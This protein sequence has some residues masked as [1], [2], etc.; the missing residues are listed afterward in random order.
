MKLWAALCLIYNGIF[1]STAHALCE[2]NAHVE[3]RWVLDSSID[4]KQFVCGYNPNFTEADYT[5]H[6]GNLN[7]E[8]SKGC[9][10][11]EADHTMNAVTQR[12][13]YQW[14]PTHCVLPKWDAISFCS[15]LGNRT[16]MIIGDSTMHQSSTTLMAMISQNNAKCAHQI[17]YGQSH[18]LIYGHPTNFKMVHQVEKF[19]RLHNH[20]PDIV[21]LTVGAHLG[22]MGDL[23]TIW[24]TPEGLIN[25]INFLRSNPWGQHHN[26]SFVWKTQNPGH[27]NCTG[28]PNPLT[29]IKIGSVDDPV[30]IFHWNIH[31]AFD[32]KNKNYSKALDIKVLDMSPLYYR[33]DGHPSLKQLLYQKKV[34]YDCLHYC[35]PGPLYLFPVLLYNMLLNREI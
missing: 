28:T 31:P 21:I 20:L 1:Q 23:T 30:D 14:V 32:E 11:D 10:C 8:Y 9:T 17:T 2:N 7:F 24:E 19:Y 3:G 35:V 13:K 15:V 4:R 25:D 12:E 22:D 18:F 5:F 33:A 6:D 29:E 26:I 34:F 27:I 16:I